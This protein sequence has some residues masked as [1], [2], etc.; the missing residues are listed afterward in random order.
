MSKQVPIYWPVP[1]AI[2]LVIIGGGFIW[3][4]IIWALV[5]HWTRS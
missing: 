4:A 2:F 1:R 3:A 5:R